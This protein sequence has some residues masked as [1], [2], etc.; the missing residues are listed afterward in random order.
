MKVD[1][2]IKIAAGAAFAVLLAALL[3]AIT[4]MNALRLY[5]AVKYP[6]FCIVP[7]CLAYTLAFTR[8][9][10]DKALLACAL[11]STVC[12]DFVMVLLQDH[13]EI[14]LIFFSAAQL[15]YCARIQLCRANRLYSAI[16][17]PL[18]AA[19]SAA[20]CAAAAVIMPS[21]VILGTAAAFYF[22]NLIINTA[23]AFA[24]IKGGKHRI[25]FAVGLLLFAGCDIC[26]GLNVGDMAGIELSKNGLY[27]VKLLIWIFYLP[28]QAMLALSAPLEE[29]RSKNV[30]SY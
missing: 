17:L 23:E 9:N 25:L 20:M 19:L 26:V 3:A 2:K 22:T 14:S 8:G 18:R 11:G 16:A 13:Y 1:I 24:L 6:E 5:D 28:S 21:D 29:Q 7:L 30:Q 27:A 4:A 12:A 15:L 10:R